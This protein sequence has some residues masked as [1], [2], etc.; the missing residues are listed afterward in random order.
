MA[1]FFF[2]VCLEHLR[3]QR[4]SYTILSLLLFHSSLLVSLSCLSLAGST[5]SSLVLLFTLSLPSSNKNTLF[6]LV[7]GFL[8][9]CALHSPKWSLFTNLDTLQMVTF[10]ENR[11]AFFLGFGTPL[12]LIC[13]YF[14]GY[15][16]DA[17][18]GILSPF[19]NK[20]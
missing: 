18:F 10:M 2:Y 16:S 8:L 19:V 7:N 13:T 12:A 11:W 17:L 6:I 5:V 4:P 15:T 1:F 9:I 3:S 14:T 20:K